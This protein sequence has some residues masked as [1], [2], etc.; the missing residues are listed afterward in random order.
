MNRKDSEDF[1]DVR[2][3]HLHVCR[4]NTHTIVYCELL[5]ALSTLT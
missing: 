1:I 3:L 5:L 4:C 2:A